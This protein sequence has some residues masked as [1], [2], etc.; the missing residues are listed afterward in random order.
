[1]LKMLSVHN[2]VSMRKKPLS[3]LSFVWSLVF[4]CQTFCNAV[5]LT[6]FFCVVLKVCELYVERFY[7]LISMMWLCHAR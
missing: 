7:W 5:I 3:C 6:S 2:V 1:M 4:A